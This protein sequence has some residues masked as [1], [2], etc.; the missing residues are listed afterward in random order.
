VS[1][2]VS[3]RPFVIIVGLGLCAVACTAAP[4]PSREGSARA[5]H[6]ALTNGDDDS[7]E[8]SF[9]VAATRPGGYRVTALNGAPVACE[10]GRLQGACNVTSIDL[11]PTALS[12]DDAH[13]IRAQVGASASRATIIFVGKI[14]PNPSLRGRVHDA[15]LVAYEVWRAPEPRALYGEWLHVSHAAEQALL[16]NWWEASSV[17]KLDL[18]RSPTM[19]YCHVVAGKF[20]CE[21]SH[22][23][24]MQDAVAPAG[25]LV[26]GWQGAD[27]VVHA[28]QYFLKVDVGQA[29]LP[30]G[31]WYCRADQALCDDGDCVADKALCGVQTAHG[32]GLLT[33]MRT[34]EPVVQPWFVSTTQLTPSETAPIQLA[35]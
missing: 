1:L 20:V 27:G 24:V 9:L 19:S 26:N 28:G 32:R 2:N 35:K 16:V 21:P 5:S 6:A 22:D 15:R 33:Y 17:S 11:A 18:A 8:Y 10:D 34:A 13:A 3:H 4:T 14:A 31:Y 25:L 30:N 7:G 12:A 23:G 29:R